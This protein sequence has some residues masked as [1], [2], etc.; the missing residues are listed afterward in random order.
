MDTRH[1]ILFFAF[2]QLSHINTPF[3]RKSRRKP[4]IGTQH[5]R[6][7]IYSAAELETYQI[8]HIVLGLIKCYAAHRIYAEPILY[9]HASISS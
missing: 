8:V 9:S 5:T 4:D 2:Q 3:C 7:Y 6:K 1:I